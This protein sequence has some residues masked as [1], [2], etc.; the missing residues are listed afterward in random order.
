MKSSL[1]PSKWVRKSARECWTQK[2]SAG[3]SALLT[4][5]SNQVHM[6]WGH[7]LNGTHPKKVSQTWNLM[8]P[9]V[10]SENKITQLANPSLRDQGNLISKFNNASQFLILGEAWSETFRAWWLVGLRPKTA[11]SSDTTN[12][13]AKVN[14]NTTWFY[15]N[16]AFK[17]E[18]FALYKVLLWLYQP[19]LD[20]RRNVIQRNEWRQL[21]T[22]ITF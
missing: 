10:V 19:P 9:P 15:P 22:K 16:S 17:G 13:L 12:P 3:W 18:M 11:Q 4:V 21:L 1:K 2:S 7:T 14:V 5:E 8:M 20:L 6:G